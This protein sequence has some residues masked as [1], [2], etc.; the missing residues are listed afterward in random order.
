M[1]SVCNKAA[2]HISSVSKQVIHNMLY[3]LADYY[4]WLSLCFIRCWKILFAS[5]IFMH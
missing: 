1:F 3:L 4:I 5:C 2:T